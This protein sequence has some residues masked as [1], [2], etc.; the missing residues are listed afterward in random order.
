MPAPSKDEQLLVKTEQAATSAAAADDGGDQGHEQLPSG[1]RAPVVDDESSSE[2]MGATGDQVQEQPSELGIDRRL[3]SSHVSW[4]H[5]S[6]ACLMGS[7]HGILAIIVRA[8]V[9][10]GTGS[11]GNQLEQQEQRWSKYSRKVLVFA[12]SMFGTYYLQGPASTT[13][14]STGE[15]MAFK[16]AIGS[17]F[18]A[19]ATLSIFMPPKWS[20]TLVYLS[21]LLL[22]IVSYL[23]LVSFNKYYV[24]A[25][26]PVPL[27]IVVALLQPKLK[28]G[29]MQQRRAHQNDEVQNAQKDHDTN[30]QD[31]Q[32]FERIFEL[33][34]DIVTYGGIITVIFRNSIVGP[35]SA[36]GFFFFCTIALGLYLMMITTVRTI[37]LIPHAKHLANLLKILLVITLITALIH[38]VS[39]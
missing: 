6:R 25:I 24:Y 27:P 26:L 20:T 39:R 30:D 14:F 11:L 2:Q 15:E 17:F 28:P 19:D 3:T 32:H 8:M 34:G 1:G 16:I 33:S 7:W 13:S 37:T 18:I 29:V 21:W 23:L 12:I 5:F 31:S 35:A 36:L 10:H 38:G 22:E 4:A 9:G